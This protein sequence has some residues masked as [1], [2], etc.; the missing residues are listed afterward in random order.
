MEA[1]P[2]LELR[3]FRSVEEI[4]SAIAKLERR[5]HELNDLDISAAVMNDSGADDTARSNIR[6]TILEIFGPNSPEFREHRY[7]DIWAGPMLHEY[8]AGR[9]CR[10]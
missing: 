8:V 9:N 4:D 5:V 6:A 7:I 1:P 10:R 2:P 3:E